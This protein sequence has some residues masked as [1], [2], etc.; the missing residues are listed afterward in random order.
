MTIDRDPMCSKMIRVSEEVHDILCDAKIIPQE[1]YNDCL[2]RIISENNYLKRHYI[3]ESPRN[4]MERDLKNFVLNPDIPDHFGSPATE[5]L[6]VIWNKL[7]PVD[8]VKEGEVIHH[9]NGDHND[10]TPENL[11][12]T[13]RWH[14]GK[15]HK[16]MNKEEKLNDENNH[17]T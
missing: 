12:K 7:S 8:P 3:S 15:L 13:S 11:Y 16:Q 17:Q 4:S 14:H 6:R 5:A 10:N 2:K 9:L 1:P